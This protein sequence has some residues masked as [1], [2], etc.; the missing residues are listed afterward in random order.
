MGRVLQSILKMSLKSMKDLVAVQIA[1]FIQFKDVLL[2]K[3]HIS[4]VYI[5]DQ[6]Y[7]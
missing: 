5:S 7:D 4:S 2:G 3:A 6:I 1:T